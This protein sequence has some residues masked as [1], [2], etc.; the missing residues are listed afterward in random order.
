MNLNDIN[1]LNTNAFNTNVLNTCLISKEIIKNKICLPCSHSYEYE[2]L[3]EE[4][5]QQKIRH[6]NYFKCPYCRSI[7]HS[8]IPFYE[9]DNV[10]KLKNINVGN[11]LHLFDCSTLNCKFPG[12]K[13]KKGNFCWK[14]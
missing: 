11:I 9:I 7:Y 13:F 6:K 3:Y 2:Y 4:I 1:Y 8:C 12:N 10:E 5:K 14:H